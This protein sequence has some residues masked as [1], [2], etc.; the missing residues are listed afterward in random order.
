MSTSPEH[1]NGQTVVALTKAFLSAQ[2]EVRLF[3]MDDGIYHIVKNNSLGA[4]QQLASLSSEKM[5]VSICTQSAEQR[6]ISEEACLETAAWFSQHEL[7]KIVAE[8]DRF[9]SF[10][11]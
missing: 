6:G 7:A 4:A 2:H 1:Q 9:L 10:G 8:T 11:N 5:T 3:L